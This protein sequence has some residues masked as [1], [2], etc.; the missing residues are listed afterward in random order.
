MKKSEKEGREKEQ[1]EQ[2]ILYENH[3]RKCPSTYSSICQLLP[4]AIKKRLWGNLCPWAQRSSV[5]RVAAKRGLLDSYA[6][7]EKRKSY[8]GEKKRETLEGEGSP[9]LAT[10][11]FLRI[12]S[13]EAR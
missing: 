4:G 13:G 5:N 11:K 6:T 1:A 10:T 3:T 9:T 12:V 2:R 7:S 8:L